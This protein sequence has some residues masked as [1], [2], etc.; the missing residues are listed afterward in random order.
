M[1]VKG[2]WSV[3]SQRFPCGRKEGHREADEVGLPAWGGAANEMVVGER[4]GSGSRGH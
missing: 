4:L 2:G 1:L 3:F